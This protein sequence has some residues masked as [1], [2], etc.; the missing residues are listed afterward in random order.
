M[1]ETPLTLKCLAAVILAL[2][3]LGCTGTPQHSAQ[4]DAELH[5]MTLGPLVDEDGR[6]RSLSLDA[7]THHALVAFQPSLADASPWYGQRLDHGPSVSAGQRSAIL[8]RSVTV[9]RDGLSSYRGR[10][11]DNFRTRSVTSRAVEIVQ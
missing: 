4:R 7:P 10:V 3:A 5:R 2:W 8:L 11:Y 1:F 9:T 6:H